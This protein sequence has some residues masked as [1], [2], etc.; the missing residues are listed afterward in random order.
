M[1][2]GRVEFIYVLEH[3]AE[4]ERD[5]GCP[6]R[7]HS[8]LHRLGK[9]VALNIFHFNDQITIDALDAIDS[10]D[11]LF[12]GGDGLLHL[13]AVFFQS[14]PLL[15]VG[16]LAAVDD[17]DGHLLTGVRSSG[18]IHDAHVAAAD[19]ADDYVVPVLCRGVHRLLS[20]DEATRTSVLRP[21]RPSN[22][23]RLS[24]SGDG[25]AG[26]QIAFAPLW[27]NVLPYICTE[28]GDRICTPGFGNARSWPLRTIVLLF[29]TAVAPSR[30]ST[31][32]PELSWRLESSRI[33]LESP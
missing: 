8:R 31:P 7:V 13:R 32:A 27:A 16:R 2:H 29:R 15:I 22:M 19:A 6:V 1:N 10:D 5:V 3:A 17:L 12:L 18:E 9:I 23:F 24:C 4:F 26:C 28:L 20:S 30:I 33:S 11:A 14:D 25:A 21:G